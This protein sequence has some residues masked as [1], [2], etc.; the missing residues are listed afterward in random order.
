M[1]D[2]TSRL[3]WFWLG[4]LALL[5]GVMVYLMSSVLGLGMNAE[6]VT[7]TQ[8][9]RH[10]L[11]AKGMSVFNHAGELAP[12]DGYPPVFPALLAAAWF[13]GLSFAEWAR[14]LNSVFFG[15]SIFLAGSI[16]YYVRGSRFAALVTAGIF[17]ASV[18][19]LKAHGLLV[20]EPLFIFLV[21]A[22]F[23]GLLVFVNTGSRSALYMA[24]LLAAASVLTS[25]YGAAFALAG[26]YWLLRQG[27]AEGKARDAFL[28]LLAVS[29]LPAVWFVRNA[30]LTGN[31][32]GISSGAVPEGVASRLLAVVSAVS[33]WL[34]PAKVPVLLHLTVLAV[35]L[36]LLVIWLKNNCQSFGAEVKRALSLA[37]IFLVL[38]FLAALSGIVPGQILFADHMKL[39][40]LYAMFALIFGLLVPV[41]CEFK[42]AYCKVA[43]GL[44]VG[45]FGLACARAVNLAL[46]LNKE[47]DGYSSKATGA[48]KLTETLRSIDDRVPLYS[49]DP[50]AVYY[51]AGRPAIMVP[52][53]AGNGALVSQVMSA[54][55]NSRRAVAVIFNQAP[56]FSVKVWEQSA[57]TLG[58][59]PLLKDKDGVILGLKKK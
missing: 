29:V 48:S 56:G 36:A 52:G 18:H 42:T 27:R 5:G 51:F 2:K 26:F 33:G 25:Y 55:F 19:I 14:L 21:L 22:G 10:F 4:G 31:I 37:V 23:R 49:N 59:V 12:L 28:F 32:L 6:A 54:D 57:A 34:L 16:V 45:F 41:A 3:F 11:L 30:V 46:I 39:V 58:L 1:E 53:G 17:M 8:A 13:I 15:G 38:F 24:A 20:A 7:Y 35:V 43:V 50:Q 9:A 47:G 40:A 44:V